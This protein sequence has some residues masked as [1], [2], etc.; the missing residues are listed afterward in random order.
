MS[1]LDSL[2]QARELQVEQAR[3][4]IRAQ[5]EATA[6]AQARTSE[7]AT[8]PEPLFNQTTMIG[9]AVAVVA[10]YLLTRKKSR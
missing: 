6:N 8:E 5:A 4:A 7:T 10:A 2:K 9:A 3:Q 1:W